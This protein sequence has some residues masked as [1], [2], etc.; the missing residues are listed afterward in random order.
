[1]VESFQNRAGLGVEGVVDGHGVIA[2][3]PA[4]MADW[5][6]IPPRALTK[7]RT[8]AEA[9]GHTAVL[10]GWD[11]AAKATFVVADAV[12]PTSAEAIQGLRDLGL[13]PMLLTGDNA[14]TARTVAAEV[15]IDDADS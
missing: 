4:L 8:E 10:A 3:R 15:G 14:A 12:K 13:T 2:G 7:A 1:P 6:Q 11:G 9:A 5:G